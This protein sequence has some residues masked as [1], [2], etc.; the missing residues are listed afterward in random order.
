MNSTGQQ[1]RSNSDSAPDGRFS[2]PGPE[3]RRVPGRRRCRRADLAI[4]LGHL[5]RK[6]LVDGIL[7][8]RPGR[9]GHSAL[10]AV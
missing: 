1:T 6:L 3:P 4:V 9:A 2:Q 5:A 7:R 8:A 10:Y